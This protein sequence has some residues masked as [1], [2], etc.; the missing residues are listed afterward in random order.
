MSQ[1]VLVFILSIVLAF[2]I[3]A[4]VRGKRKALLQQKNFK[5]PLNSAAKLNRPVTAS[6]LLGDLSA[7]ALNT[8]PCGKFPEKSGREQGA[9]KRENMSPCGI[10]RSLRVTGFQCVNNL[11]MLR[12]DFIHMDNIG[13]RCRPKALCLRMNHTQNI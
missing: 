5:S 11:I 3:Y 7:K 8:S 13:Q 10:G 9:L 12:N 1:L 2:S 6:R 4:I